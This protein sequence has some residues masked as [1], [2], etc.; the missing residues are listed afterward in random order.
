MNVG[1]GPLAGPAARPAQ[2]R[3]GG[4]VR[5][6]T[7]L[8]GARV[9]ARARGAATHSWKHC[10]CSIVCERGVRATPRGCGPLTARE[11]LGSA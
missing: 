5:Q 3:Q 2:G 9:P 6:A 7:L 1:S 4:R 10:T 11:G 8:R